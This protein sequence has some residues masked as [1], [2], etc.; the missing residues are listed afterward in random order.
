MMRYAD[1]HIHCTCSPDAEGGIADMAAAA[2]R[3]G[4]A[5]LCF[6]DHMDMADE[7]TGHTAPRFPARWPLFAARRE[8][9]AARPAP[10][11]EVRF[12]MELGEPG[13]APELAAAAA[14]Q[15]GLD[16][17]IASVHN[18]PDVPDFYE[19]P[20]RDEAECEALNR[21]YLAE[22]RRTAELDCFDV[23][24]HIGYTT[25]YMAQR[26][27]RERITVA[28]YGDE[29]RELLARLIDRGKGIE[30]NAS[31]FRDGGDAPYPGEDILR[32][33]RSLGGEII[34]VGSDGHTPEQASKHVREVYG[35][36]KACAFRA[37][38]EYRA[39]RPEFITL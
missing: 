15:P 39:R 23:A 27:F 4:M 18:L 38:C 13:Q 17:V 36:L 20:F 34:T 26:G 5:L 9:Y 16:L 24:G 31:G 35:L 10:G 12:G 14:G 22:L 25:R 29:L 37:V 11:L 3:E 19:Y 33:Y 7:K 32:L 1:Q 6:T 30:C 21:R 8:E 28:K 2:A